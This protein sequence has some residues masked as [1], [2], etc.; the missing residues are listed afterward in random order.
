MSLYEKTLIPEGYKPVWQFLLK[1]YK[2]G[3]RLPVEP[4]L[5]RGIGIGR[6]KLREAMGY[7][8]QFGIVERRRKAGS[9]MRGLDP[10]VLGDYMNKLIG[11]NLE[12]FETT[13]ETD[14]GA[15]DL[16]REARAALESAAALQC[17]INRK[18]KDLAEMEL[19]ID[20]MVVIRGL[21]D[22]G[23]KVGRNELTSWMDADKRFH[24]AVLSGTYNKH[25]VFLVGPLVSVFSGAE[26][27]EIDCGG[28]MAGRIIDEH[29]RILHHIGRG[30]SFNKGEMVLDNALAARQEMYQHIINPKE[31][32][33]DSVPAL[34]PWVKDRY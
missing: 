18:A 8:E 22:C 12:L 3:D 34:R 6:L 25:L 5:A 31:G 27:T 13:L 33:E 2:V 29:K 23:G 20:D 30:I 10:A 24:R 19:A 16:I 7:L 32:G 9:F 14:D 21:V 26:L 15:I 28:C 4:E 1:N 17:T 11:L